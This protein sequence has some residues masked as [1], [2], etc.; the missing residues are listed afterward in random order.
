MWDRITPGSYDSL[1]IATNQDIRT[2]TNLLYDR[3]GVVLSVLY[4]VSK[5]VGSTTVRWCDTFPQGQTYYTIF[6]W[7]FQCFFPPTTLLP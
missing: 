6:D 2:Y 5:R 7:L 1:L 3:L 4:S